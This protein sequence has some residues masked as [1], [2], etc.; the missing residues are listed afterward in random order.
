M[1]PENSP[2]CLNSQFHAI[3]PQAALSTATNKAGLVPHEQLRSSPPSCRF[4]VQITDPA[5]I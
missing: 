5:K 2:V 3:D 1:S 4:F